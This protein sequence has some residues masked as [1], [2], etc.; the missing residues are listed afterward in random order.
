MAMDKAKVRV[1]FRVRLWLLVSLVTVSV[2]SLANKPK[3]KH[4]LKK[5]FI[6]SCSSGDR[7]SE[8]RSLELDACAATRRVFTLHESMHVTQ[9]IKRKPLTLSYEIR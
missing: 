3:L 6:S 1:E 7:N 5:L 4:F 2:C 9:R 8:L